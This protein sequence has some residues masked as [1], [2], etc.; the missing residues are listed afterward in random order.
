VNYV[1]RNRASAEE[2]IKGHQSIIRRTL[3]SRSLRLLPLPHQV[4]IVEGLAAIM[5]QVRD[6]VPLND[7]HVLAF[8]SELLKMAS[9]ADGEMTDPALKGLVVDKN[10]FAKSV[11]SND[12]SRVEHA[13]TLFFRRD[14]TLKFDQMSV[15]LPGE[16]PCGVQLRISTIVLLH[17]AIKANSD[18]FFDAL[19]STPVGK[20]F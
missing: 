4:G 15:V 13:S 1:L 3:F 17:A 14:L 18:P 12:A 19:T 5:V 11:V 10:G 7:Q 20:G 8:L 9:V 6:L 16:L 2:A